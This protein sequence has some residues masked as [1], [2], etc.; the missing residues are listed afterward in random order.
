MT[1][2]TVQFN[3]TIPELAT[4]SSLGQKRFQG[5]LKDWRGTHK[6]EF[7]WQP[8]PCTGTQQK[9]LSRRILDGFW[10]DVVAV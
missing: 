4:V 9:T 2:Y 5:T 3:S 8:V 10:N 1:H 6:H 7:S